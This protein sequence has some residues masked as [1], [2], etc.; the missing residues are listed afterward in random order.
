MGS[1]GT[2]CDPKFCNITILFIFS[3]GRILDGAQLSRFQTEMIHV[4]G[5]SDFVVLWTHR[6]LFIVAME[7]EKSLIGLVRCGRAW[8]ASWAGG[9]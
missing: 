2:D 3:L 7:T 1:W 4:E 5:L 9:V 6:L 8:I